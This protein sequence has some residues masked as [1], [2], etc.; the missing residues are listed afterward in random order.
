MVTLVGSWLLSAL[1]LPQ[2]LLPVARHRRPRRGRSRADRADRRGVAGAPLRPAG[3]PARQRTEAGGFVL[4]LSLGLVFVPCAGPVLA[5][6]AVVGADH[7]FGWSCGGADRV[8]RRSASPYRCSSSRWPASAWPTRM[9]PSG[10]GRPPPGGSSAPS[11][12]SPPL[13]I[14]LNLTDGLQRAVP[15]YTDALQS[16]IEGNASATLALGGSTGNTASA[17]P[18]PTCTPASPVLQQCGPAPALAG[19]SRWLN[20]PGDRPLTLAGLTGPGGPGRLLDLLVHQLPAVASPRRGLERGR[21]PSRRPDRGRRPH[22]GVRLR[23]R[24]R[25]R[26]PGV[27]PARGGLP[28]GRQDND[29]ATWNAYENNYWPAEYLVDATGTV[30]HVDFGEGEYGQTES[31]IRQLLVA[32]HPAVHLPAPH[33]R[34]RSHAGPG[35]HARELPGLSATATPNLAGQTVVEDRMTPIRHRPTVPSGRVRLRRRLVRSVRRRR[36]PGPG[37]R[38]PPIPGPATSTWCSE[39]PGTVRVSLGG[40]PTRTVTVGGEPTLYQLVGSVPQPAGATDP[41]G[42]TRGCRP[43]TSRSAD[44]A[45]PRAAS[46]LAAPRGT[47]GVPRSAP[48]EPSTWAP[49]R[50]TGV[51]LTRWARPVTVT[52]P[53]E[54]PARASPGTCRSG[55]LVLPVENPAPTPRGVCPVAP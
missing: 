11:W 6:I 35:H 39:A 26:G 4:G 34:G 46:V 53:G 14:G 47:D 28:G 33:G 27:A 45:A 19:I 55:P 32:A 25:Q 7:R 43:T 40:R 1:G 12:S 23:A 20:T 52:S 9:R 50:R 51:R 29:Y 41:G 8:L 2:D 44:A 54:Q 18:W 31:F 10:P 13:V 38:S 22:A 17:A 36:R 37:P 5:A 21:T 49:V 15:G 30:R 24:D 16:H 48:G 3:R 42:V